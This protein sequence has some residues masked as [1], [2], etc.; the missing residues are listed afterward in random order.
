MAKHDWDGE[1]YGAPAFN[2]TRY[3][4]SRSSA[5]I[6][7]NPSGSGYQ[8]Q[9]YRPFY[10]DATDAMANKGFYVSFQHAPSLQDVNFKAFITAFNES[11]NCDWAAEQ[12]YG[13]ADPIYMFKQ[14][15]RDITLALN[16]PAATVGEA[17]D[18]LNKV[19]RLVTFLYPTYDDYLGGTMSN[20]ANQGDT[21]NGSK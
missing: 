18:N 20:A 5:K 13:R 12:V 8:I 11:Y 6:V 7:Q 9:S 14:N 15:T 21:T 10:V 19:Q 4:G 16:I 1:G 17:F 2:V 3:G